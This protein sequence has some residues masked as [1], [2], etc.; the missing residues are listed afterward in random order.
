[1]EKAYQSEKTAYK[2]MGM[3]RVAVYQSSFL[4][5]LEKG[6]IRGEERRELWIEGATIGSAMVSL[7]TTPG[8]ILGFVS[9]KADLDDP[10]QVVPFPD[11][12]QGTRTLFRMD[13]DSITSSNEHFNCQKLYCNRAGEYICGV[14]QDEEDSG[15]PGEFGGCGVEGYDLPGFDD[16]PLGSQCYMDDVP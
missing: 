4:P 8:C 11:G 6:L 14:E 10:E 3:W 2:A 16:C 13:W 5:T 9:G 15:F 12:W 7:L 1:M